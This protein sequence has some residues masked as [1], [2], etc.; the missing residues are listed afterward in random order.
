MQAE[1]NEKQ[2]EPIGV[3]AADQAAKRGGSERRK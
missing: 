2:V 3:A 1:Q